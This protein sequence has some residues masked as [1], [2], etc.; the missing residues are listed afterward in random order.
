MLHQIAVFTPQN[1]PNAR[2][3]LNG[4]DVS[5]ECLAANPYEGWVDLI[6][7]DEYGRLTVD[8]EGDVQ[9]ERKRGEVVVRIGGEVQ[10]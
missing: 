2:T 5:D 7:I 10:A 6:V 4:T 3:F 1:S 9:T 8:S